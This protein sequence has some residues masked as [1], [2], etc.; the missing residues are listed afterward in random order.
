MKRR[1]FLAA[2]RRAPA[3]GV[4]M[5]IALIALLLLMIG[6][7]AMV[8]A[9]GASSAVAGNLAFRRDLTNQGERGFAAARAVLKTGALVSETA[10]QTSL[11]AANY[12]AQRLQSN[13]EGIPLPLLKDS[14]FASSGMSAGNDIVDDAAGV[15]VRYVIDRQCSGSGA[16]D[17]ASCV[18]GEGSADSGG[19]NWLKKP[20]AQLRPVYRVTVRVTGPRG[21]QAYLQTT[22]SY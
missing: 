21:T 19:S 10:R 9:I 7:V 5:L 22:F 3:R 15:A 11:P 6:A 8:R 14:L 18:A 17:D 4:S 16:F 1:A 12:S 20:G 2:G 13:D